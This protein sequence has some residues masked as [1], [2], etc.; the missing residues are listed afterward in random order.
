MFTINRI[1]CIFLIFILLLQLTENG[2]SEENKAISLEPIILSITKTPTEYSKTSRNIGIINEDSIDKSNAKS[3]EEL[4]KES[5]SL[6]TRARGPYGVQADLSVRGST[7]SQNLILI[8]GIKVN[9]PQT[10]HHNFDLGLTLDSIEKIEILPGHGSSLYGADAFGGTVN[11]VTKE[12]QERKFL[13]NTSYGRNETFLSSLFYS[14]KWD[15]ASGFVSFE[16]KESDGY[17]YDTDFNIQNFTAFLNAEPRAGNR[18]DFLLGYSEKEFGANDFY[19]AYPSK[20][21]TKTIFNVARLKA[22]EDICLEP[23]LYFRRHY[24][25]FILDISRPSFYRNDHMTDMYGAET[26]LLIPVDNILNKASGNILFGAEAGQEE[27]ESTNLGNHERGHMAIFTNGNLAIF[28]RIMLDA[29]VRVDSY[30]KFNEQ[31]SPSLGAAYIPFSDFKL[32]VSAGRS[33]RVPSYTEFY[34]NSPSDKG[35][36]DLNPEEAWSY[37]AGADYKFGKIVPLDISLTLFKR[38]EKDLIDWIKS[39]PG[40]AKYE[41]QNIASADI[42]G[43][44]AKF[45]FKPLDFLSA[46]FSYSYIDSD[47]EKEGN[48]ISKYALNHPQHQFNGFLDFVLPFGNQRISILYKDRNTQR[49]YLLLDTRLSARLRKNIEL[50]LDIFNMLDKN[51]EENIGVPMPGISF[52]TGVKAEF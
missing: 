18:I 28:E 2:F 33:F 1:F 15:K 40:A 4:L 21:W 26:E 36:A 34:Y 25:K 12:P 41:A 22:G 38:E 29:G 50:Y 37:E 3:V 52:Q 11:I 39:P 23:K 47:I 27:I 30:D 13:V 9:D 7:Y 48:Y 31:Y 16:N 46:A 49:D 17:R 35:N 6:E 8:D 24:D 20:E 51:Y 5:G 44:E 19:G 14:D 42:E 10:A 32:R 45:N 43:L